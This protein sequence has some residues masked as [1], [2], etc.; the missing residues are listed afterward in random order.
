MA[1]A[2]VPFGRTSAP[3]TL[4]DRRPVA[5]ADAARGYSDQP[6]GTAW[7]QTTSERET[8]LEA[9][10]KFAEASHTPSFEDRVN[11]Y[12]SP[13]RANFHDWGWLD[14]V[15]WVIAP[16]V[17]VGV[18]LV[19]AI[20]SLAVYAVILGGWS[21]NSKYSFLGALRSSAQL[22]SYEIPLGLA[23]LG[24]FYVTGSLNLERIHRMPATSTAGTS[25]TSSGRGPA[26]RGQRLRGVQDASPIRPAGDRSRSWWAALPHLSTPRHEAGPVPCWPNTST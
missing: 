18:V 17:D 19:F 12:N 14:E 7:P 3:P 21:S 25:F 23:V 16:H 22:I 13:G 1:F 10:R 8:L 9:D 20:G 6:H 2:V 15:Q 5:E 24:V 4:L 26:V 11:E